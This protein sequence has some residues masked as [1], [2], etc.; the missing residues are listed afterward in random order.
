M[1]DLLNLML[2]LIQVDDD[3]V[4]KYFKRNIEANLSRLKNLSQI[5][6]QIEGTKNGKFYYAVYS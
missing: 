2:G 6:K 1:V 4:K 3:F 5:V